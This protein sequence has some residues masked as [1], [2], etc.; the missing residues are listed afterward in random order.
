MGYT[1][2]VAP[3]TYNDIMPRLRKNAQ[4]A[5]ATCTGGASGTACGLKWNTGPKF[6]GIMG[7]GE[8]LS[9]LEVIQNTAPFV[10]P[11]GYL[12]DID[13]GGVSKSNPNGTGTRGGVHNRNSQYLPYRL[14]N[15][16][17]TLAD[18]VGAAIITLVIV[19]VFALGARFTMIH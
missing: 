14:R 15:Y 13:N 9:A 7:L 6:D 1:A 5:A 11:V 8:Q 18:R 19:V 17:I 4:L 10:A 2:Q 16:E 12:V 3:Y